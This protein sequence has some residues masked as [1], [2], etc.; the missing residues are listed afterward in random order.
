M[1]SRPS[2][3]PAT[4][5]APGRSL[6]A[7]AALAAVLA[8]A[9]CASQ[10]PAHQPLARLGSADVGLND[11]ANL[12]AADATAL[13]SSQW[14]TSLGDTRLNQLIDQALA[15]SPSLAASNARFE[16]AAAL[17]TA[18]STA[19]DVRGTLSADATRQRYTANGMIPAPIAGNIYNSGNLQA[20][21]SWSPDFFG[22]HGA[23]LQAALGQAR[24][25]KA[26][27][28]AA[29]NQL[30]AQVAR[31]YIA[32]ARL[33]AQKEVAER[34][35]GQR[36]SLLSLSEQRTRAGLDSQVELTQAQ[37]GMPDAQTQI[38]MLGEQITLA[39]RTIAVLCAQAP[40]AQNALSPR[41]SVLRIQPVP[42]AL[43]ADLLGR[44]PDVVAARWRVEAATQGIESA[45]ADFYPDVNLTAFV[46]LNALGLDNLLQ[47]SSRQMGITPALR[48]PIFDGKRLRAQLRGKQAD[49]DTAIAQYNGAVL[50]AVKQAGD[51]IASVQSLQRQ[52][53]LQTESLSK[54]ERA[55]D[56]AVQRYQAGLG[57]QITVL[58]TETQLINQ[59]RLAVDL[60]ARE[61]DTRVALAAALGGGWSD[62]TSAV[63]VQ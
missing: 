29:A 49:L 12:G 37:A 9:G 58:N 5:C 1:T 43:G 46:G 25:A 28:A 63:A 27:S 42:Q 38:E 57:S 59:R 41:L 21:L 26:D 22:K 6:L 20:G 36:Q 23:D 48:L 53:L 24:A 3:K 44:R 17:A 15:G 52:Q 62:D 34:T 55:Y 8:L 35:L 32:L 45:R 2:R 4:E 11:S 40:D 47:G 51:A 33:I 30:A 19:S 60:Q 14:W 54:A 16:K 18:S 56:F 50:D 39:R 31:S 13:A 10:G 61:L 7:T